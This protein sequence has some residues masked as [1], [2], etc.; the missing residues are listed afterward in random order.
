MR[1]PLAANLTTRD[2]TLT[3][4]AKIV[5]GFV[6]SRGEE[7][8]VFKRPGLINL[9]SVGTGLAQ[10]L[11]VWAG[12]VQ[13][14]VG[15]T[16]ATVIGILDNEFVAHVAPD[17]DASLE[18]QAAY[19]GSDTFITIGV[20]VSIGESQ[21]F[22]VDSAYTLTELT[23]TG[24]TVTD[25]FYD[26]VSN[27][28][29]MV[30][31]PRGVVN[32]LI[33]RSAV[34]SPQAFTLVFTSAVTGGVSI[35]G[36]P[37]YVGGRYVVVF[38]NNSLGVCNWSVANSVL[39]AS[40]G[41]YEVA[42]TREVPSYPMYD[43]VKWII[44]GTKYDSMGAYVENFFYTT[45]DFVTFTR[46]TLTG[47]SA[48]AYYFSFFGGVYY[49]LSSVPYSSEDGV[50]FSA[51]S[52]LPATPGIFSATENAIYFSPTAG[53][54][55]YRRTALSDF[56]LYVD[57]SAYPTL[58][59]STAAEGGGNTIFIEASPAIFTVTGGA[60]VDS[61]D[62][63]TPITA[64]LPFFY[65]VSGSAQSNQYMM[66]KNSE[67]AFLFDGTTVSLITDVDYPG[68]HTVAV[69]SITRVSTTAT[70][71]TT[72]AHPF[73]TGDTV[74]IAGASPAG[75]NGAKTVT[76]TG[77]STFTY[78]IAGSPATPATG[79]ITAQ[80]GS[81]RTVPGIVYLD[82]YFFVMTDQAVIYNSDLGDPTT[83]A[84]LDFIT[85]EIEP[86]DGVALTKTQNY[87]C[88]F[89]EWST[90]FFYDAANATGSPLS[91][92]MNGFTLVGC[93]SGASVAT[94]SS[95][96]NSQA[97][98]IFWISQTK[99]KGRG[100]YK[101]V[102]TTQTQVSTPDV[103]RVLTRSDLSEVFAYGVRISGHSFYILTLTD[104][105]VTL[106]Y[107]STSNSWATWSSLTA[108]ASTVQVNFI[109]RSGTTATVITNTAHGLS[110]GDP[111]TI[112]GVPQTEY[113]GIFQ[114]RYVDT[115]T[116]TIEVSGGPSTPATGYTL[117]SSIS[118][119]SLSRSGTTATA[120]TATSHGLTTGDLVLI[121]GATQTDYNG[122][123]QVTVTDAD[124]FTYTVEGSPV[125]PATGTITE[126][127][128]TS[129]MTADGFAETYFKLTYYTYAFGRDLVLHETNG[130]LYEITES[131]FYD[132]D[133]PINLLLRTGK[134]DGGSTKPKLEGRC[135]V[136]GNKVD[137]TAMIRHSDDD[138]QTNSKYRLVNLNAERSQ[139]WRQGRFRR[140]SYDLRFIENT[141]L[142]ISSLEL[143]LE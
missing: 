120:N 31:T 14:L 84:A 114:I 82:G 106:A 48:P 111:V 133:A 108:N 98:S 86:G 42:Q 105:N 9:G 124:T 19:I 24:I 94:I 34:A 2:G 74:T 83:W 134:L 15:D 110:D 96:P 38:R 57:S 60:D 40:W 63:I 79:T 87:V 4:D 107:D 13:A 6:E 62:T 53:G 28:T 113:N 55:L 128:A 16:L 11:A 91:P 101:M 20:N 5:N 90:E 72:A 65:N 136:I 130:N 123:F 139:I 7:A 116:F 121:A 132:D 70:V 125:S 61:T 109:T 131:V 122:Y 12:Q 41:E 69:T 140:R 37:A 93:A 43:G 44:P 97:A 52:S 3:K 26:A 23:P 68:I 81:K 95:D 29:T 58:V 137:A 47:F 78:T 45:T 8:G 119:S 143:D 71:T 102:G 30:T 89:K 138:Y 141:Q 64:D 46:V 21:V 100:V 25:E 117:G 59:V 77:G 10:L 39:G 73:I 85:A 66:L 1:L 129:I 88:A 35:F 49:A 18:G 75:Y 126:K 27:Q 36:Y 92:V 54:D 104:I 142:Q 51:A 76:V 67:Q 22:S 115:T 118:V 56:S 50:A 135:E 17:L 80:G 32:G 99:E 103:E 127:E 112:A 33:Y